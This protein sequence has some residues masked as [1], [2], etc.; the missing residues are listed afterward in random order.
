M[1][2]NHPPDLSVRYILFTFA[3]PQYDWLCQGG[4][5]RAGPGAE[6]SQPTPTTGG[7]PRF[8]CTLA[9]R[10]WLA[11]IG[12]RSCR[13]ALEGR[14]RPCAWTLLGHFLCSK[15]CQSDLTCPERRRSGGPIF[16]GVRPSHLARRVLLASV[17]QFFCNQQVVGS[18]P[19]AGSLNFR[20]AIG[21]SRARLGPLIANCA[22][23]ALEINPLEIFGS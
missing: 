8:A 20:F 17:N 11:N 21:L 1:S 3:A 16:R 19:T 22:G 4:M 10:P 7:P 15:P 5:F 14:N 2:L 6:S 23:E 18:N 12:D 13:N 9:G